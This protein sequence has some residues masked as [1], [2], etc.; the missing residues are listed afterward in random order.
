MDQKLKHKIEDDVSKRLMDLST[1]LGG[2]TTASDVVFFDTD[3]GILFDKVGPHMVVSL[4]IVIRHE[5][6][7]QVNPH[8]VPKVNVP[9]KIMQSAR[10]K[11]R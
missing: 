5:D 10:S 9:P 4:A 11:K 3:A 7:M 1:S 8:M 6:Y 2:V